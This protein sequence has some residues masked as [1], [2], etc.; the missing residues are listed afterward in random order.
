MAAPKLEVRKESSIAYIEHEGPYDKI[1]WDAYIRRLYEWAKEQKVIPGFHPMGIYHDQPG[2][3][4]PSR[5]R[6]EIAITF[7]GKAR[8]HGGIRTR[9]L[10]SMRIATISF[11]GPASEY[12]KVY[13]DLDGWI[14]K[15]GYRPTGPPMETYSK[16]PEVVD[17]VTILC[18]KVMIPVL[19]K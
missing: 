7:R 2:K 10:P 15:K 12:G 11:K 16:K 13:A 17:G 5:Q 3:A 4:Q 1:P 14:T 19:K 8:G 9:R 18:S 6:T